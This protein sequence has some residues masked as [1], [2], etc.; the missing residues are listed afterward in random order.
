MSERFLLEWREAAGLR[1]LA[2]EGAGVAAVF[3]TREGGVSPAPWE[4]LDLGLLVGDESGR[5]LE[6][7][8][9]LCAAIGLPLERL[10]VPHQVHGTHLRWVGGPAAGR[11]AFDQTTA[12][13][14][15]DGLLTVTP[16]LGLA[17]STADC[18]PVVIAAREERGVALAAV[19]AGW[20]GVIEGIAGQAAACLARRGPLLG[21]VVGPSIGPCC[22]NVDEALRA[23]FARRFPG[24]VRG[25]AIDLWEAV[26]DDLRASGVPP[27]GIEVA[28]VCTASDVSF[29][30]HRRDRGLTG[31]HLAI[32]WR[33]ET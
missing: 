22:F 25:T 18:L 21:A 29:F 9:R 27:G 11:G 30:S 8:R 13:S 17:V 15:C 28:G 20:R 6:N 3:P 16:R 31:R 24:V 32:A 10:V 1:W 2:W 5:V 26:V 23:R 19:H 33:Q 7:R 4:T 12:V 14:S